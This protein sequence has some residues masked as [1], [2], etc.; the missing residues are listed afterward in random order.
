MEGWPVGPSRV[1]QFRLPSPVGST[2]ETEHDA[3]GAEHIPVPVSE[4]RMEPPAEFLEP[5][6]IW[7]A[8]DIR[9]LDI[10]P[11]RDPEDPLDVVG[12]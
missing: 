6:V 12:T 11:S 4:V 9:E 10:L 7:K 5:L 1:R 8:H 3:R 2:T